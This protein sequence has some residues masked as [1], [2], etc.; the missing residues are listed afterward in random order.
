MTENL[1]FLIFQKG[2]AL[3]GNVKVRRSTERIQEKY[4]NH[5]YYTEF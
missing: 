1:V 3:E 2:L 4:S 5:N